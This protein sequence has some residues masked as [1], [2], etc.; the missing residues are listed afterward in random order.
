V[1]EEPEA[2]VTVRAVALKSRDRVIIAGEEIE[3]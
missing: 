3:L 1:S 2:I